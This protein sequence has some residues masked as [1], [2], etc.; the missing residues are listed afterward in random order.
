MHSSWPRGW[1]IVLPT[2]INGNDYNALS[3]V[4]EL[5]MVVPD[6]LHASIYV[7]RS[8]GIGAFALRLGMILGLSWVLRGWIS[9]FACD[10]GG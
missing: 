4:V 5:V 7:S 6:R 2:R 8:D 1:A 9:S 10:T 3:P